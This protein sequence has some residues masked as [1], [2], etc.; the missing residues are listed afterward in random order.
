MPHAHAHARAPLPH[1]QVEPSCSAGGEGPSSAAAQSRPLVKAGERV[2]CQHCLLRR[3]LPRVPR[4]HSGPAAAGSAGRGGLQPAHLPLLVCRQPPGHSTG[5]KRSWAC[6]LPRAAQHLRRWPPP[7][8]PPAPTRRTRSAQPTPND[9]QAARRP[10]GVSW[11]CM[12]WL[13]HGFR[14]E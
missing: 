7:A 4:R 6:P 14:M 3:L 12:L 8:G 9:A 5:H 2:G 11:W 1:T 10:A 13:R